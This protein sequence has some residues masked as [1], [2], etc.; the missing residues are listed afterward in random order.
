MTY[1]IR[2]LISENVKRVVM[3][4]IDPRGNVIE[5]TGRN[6]QGK[7]SVL[8]SIWW[9]LAG[10]RNIQI[11]PI[12]EGEEEARIFLDL[13]EMRVQRTFTKTNDGKGY[14]T[15]LKITSDT[16]RKAGS[17]TLL[18]SFLG[19]L[20][21]DPLKFAGA[22]P[23][24]QYDQLKVLVTGFDF[25]EN[26]RQR[27]EIF[28][29]RTEVNNEV[30]ALRARAESIET[31]LKD[32]EAIDEAPLIEKLSNAASHNASI[33]ERQ[34]K[35][36]DVA[37][38]V[39]RRESRMRQIEDERQ[40][41]LAEYNELTE[42]NEVDQ[43][44]LDG[45]PPLPDPIDTAAV[46]VQ[47]E[48]ARRHNASLGRA[49]ERRQLIKD[50]DVR[51]AESERLTKAIEALDAAKAAAVANAKLPVPGLGFGDG[52]ITLNGQPFEQASDMEQL[53][54]SV[55]IAAAQHPEI[56]VILVRDGSKIDSEQWQGLVDIAAE[57]D[58]QIWVETVE[59]D[60]PTAVII[61]DGHVK[62][63]N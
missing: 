49:G 60:R 19:K 43:A 58:C 36:A 51:V 8:N 25:A 26:A 14:T 52:F 45:A 27:A 47:L 29:E 31:P 32:V 61:E 42:A 2:K 63:A 46:A 22:K 55:A 7:T 48:E 57:M 11:N 21:F 18:T 12:R 1:R 50:A 6:K 40:R 39:Q 4:E 20:S 59:S 10:E 28:A 35:R 16:G 54:T 62:G 24:E 5:L 33:A 9:A 53:R 30:K 34:R 23:E 38:E 13:G 41:L 3:V 56:R 17:Q 37:A 15:D 44:R